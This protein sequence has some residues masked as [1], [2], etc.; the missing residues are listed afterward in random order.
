MTD[1]RSCRCKWADD[2]KT[3]TETCLACYALAYRLIQSHM[4]HGRQALI[5]EGGKP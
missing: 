4:P 2:G 5:K 1:S 3:R